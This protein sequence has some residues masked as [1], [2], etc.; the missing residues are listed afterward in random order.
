MFAVDVVA[1]APPGY[2][3]SGGCETLSACEKGY[4][5]CWDVEDGD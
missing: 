1:F 4:L 3:I 2:D 5:E